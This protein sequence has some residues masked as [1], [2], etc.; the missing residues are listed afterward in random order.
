MTKHNFNSEPFVI[1]PSSKK[2]RKIF[3]TPESLDESREEIDTL[4]KE[5]L[6]SG[7]KIEGITQGATGVVDMSKPGRMT[8]TYQKKDRLRSRKKKETS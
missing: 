7:G 1:T 6:D 4:T 5:F 2:T 3:S 8:L